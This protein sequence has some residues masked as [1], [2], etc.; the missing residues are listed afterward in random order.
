MVYRFP[1]SGDYDVTLTAYNA[2]TLCSTLL[3]KIIK[4]RNV[5][6]AFLADRVAC[7]GDS[8]KFNASSSVDYS[9]DCYNEGFLWNFQDNTPRRRTFSIP[10]YHV[11]SD[12]GTFSPN[13]IV[14]ADNGCED[15]VS[16]MISVRKP[17]ASFITNTDEGCTS[18][19][20]VRFT[21]TGTDTVPVTWE[22]AFGD[23]TGDISSPSAV[24]HT[25]TSETSQTYT[26]CLSVKDAY[27]CKASFCIPI[28]L[29]EPEISFES[30]KNFICAGENVIF[31]APYSN[32]D[33]FEWDFGDGS[34]SA[35]SH[36][37]VYSSPGIFDVTLSAEKNGCRDTLQR[38]QYIHAEKADATYSLYDSIFDCYPATEIFTYRGRQPGG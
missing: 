19:L 2:S 21:K 35:I 12:T 32:F 37:H 24:Q 20:T 8:V 6:A 3:K 28:T 31:N 5:K 14:R 25:Y 18:G 27:G 26:A 29:G 7:L 13:L 16:R 38:K 36:S 17:D 10:Y 9:N 33:S 22:W 11:F 30:D 34:T 1:S 4:V 15:T 23:N